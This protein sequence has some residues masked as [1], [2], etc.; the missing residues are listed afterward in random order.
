MHAWRWLFVSILVGCS[1][2]GGAPRAEDSGAEDS[3]SA[4]D[5]SP[6][7]DGGDETSGPLAENTRAAC[8]DG[9]DNDG[10]GYFDCGDK[11]CCAV[12]DCSGKPTSYCGR[13]ENNP[14]TCTDGKDNDG[15]GYIDC[16]DIGCCAVVDCAKLAPTSYCAKKAAPPPTSEN[17]AT[18][19]SNGK[20]DDGDGFADCDDKGCCGVVDCSAKPTTYCG[21]G[22]CKDPKFPV[23]CPPRGDVAA[24]C[25]TAGTICSTVTSCGGVYKACSTAGSVVDCAASTC[26]KP[27]AS[28]AGGAE[29]VVDCT[30]SDPSP[31]RC[32]CTPKDS[33]TGPV[34]ITGKCEKDPSFAPMRCCASSGYP[35]SG[36]CACYLSQP[37][38]CM[39][40][41]SFGRCSCDYYWDAK[42]PEYRTS[43]C[44]AVPE[45]DGTPWRCCADITHASCECNRKGAACATGE[46][47]VKDCT[48]DKKLGIT[49]FTGCPTGQVEALGCSGSPTGDCTKDSDCGGSCS[50]EDPVCCSVCS[51]GRCKLSCCGTLGCF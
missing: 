24:S 26:V 46:V 33:S 40:F 10:D 1:S 28:D 27:P 49:P 43:V 41:A 17:T 4:T 36:T 23:F 2:E 29:H 32:A 34:R 8:S 51:G 14:V 50:G 20:D 16:G 19:C 42:T 44:D 39:G 15:D 9:K 11:D 31:K 13:L 5:T 18:A 45:P 12:V 47:E 25:W 35:K 37:W 21:G 3:G 7:L 22:A 30:W 48:S 38:G 6:P